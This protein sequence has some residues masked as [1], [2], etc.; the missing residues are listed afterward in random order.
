MPP[1]YVVPLAQP[2]P[3]SRR[4]YPVVTRTTPFPDAVDGE[5]QSTPVIP[6]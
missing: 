4:E 6:L 2:G 5:S 1:R 3:E